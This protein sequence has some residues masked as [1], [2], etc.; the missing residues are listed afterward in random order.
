MTDQFSRY[1]DDLVQLFTAL[2]PE[3]AD[4]YRA[5]EDDDEPGMMVTVATDDDVSCWSYQTG[6]NSFT[7]GAYGLPHWAVI[8]LSRESNPKECAAD[9]ANQWGDLICRR[10][11]IVRWPRS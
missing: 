2:I 4:G 10:Y 5:S 9:I 1:N 3:I 6:D 8:Y 7:G 11:S